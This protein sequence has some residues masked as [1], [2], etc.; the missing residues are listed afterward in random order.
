MNMQQMI[1]AVQKMQ[2]EYSKEHAK[3]E[4]TS[5]E[6]TAN[7]LVKCVLKGNFTLEKLEI[8]D[9]EALTSDNKEMLEEMIALA[10]NNCKDQIMAKEDELSAKYQKGPGGMP[11]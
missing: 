5:F 3:L 10:Y 6:Y 2:R 8:L 4:E 9:P 7:G 1:Q 11:L